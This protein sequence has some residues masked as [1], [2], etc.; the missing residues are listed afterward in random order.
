MEDM[1]DYIKQNEKGLTLIEVLASLVILS[2]VLIS[3]S[4]LLLQ[5]TKHTKYNK[6]KL[7]EVDVAEQVIGDIRGETSYQSILER[8]ETT[9]YPEDYSVELSCKKGPNQLNEATV[10]VE[11]ISQASQKKSAFITQ[12]YFKGEATCDETE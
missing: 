6:E 12:T 8:T 11:A 10:K 5:A 9:Y 2:I 7:T 1:K 3:F 4:S